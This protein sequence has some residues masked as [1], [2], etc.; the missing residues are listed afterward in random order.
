VFKPLFPTLKQFYSEYEMPLAQ[1]FNAIDRRGLSVDSAKLEAFKT[2]LNSELERACLWVE[3]CVKLKVVPK[4]PKGVK[5]PKGTLNLSSPTQ[6][7]KVFNEVLGIHFKKDRDTGKETS[8]EEALNEAY[9]RTGNAALKQVIIIRELNKIKGTYAEATLVD[10]VLY[11]SYNPAGTVSGRRSSRETPFTASDGRTIGTNVQNLPKHSELGLAF[12]ECIVARPGCVF[13]SCDQIS[14]EDWVVQAIIADNGGGSKGLDELKSGVN[15]HR[16]L[17]C[18]IFKKTPQ[19]CGKET[20][21]YFLGKKTR[22]AGNYGMTAPRMAEVLIKEVPD[23]VEGM[24]KTGKLISYCDFMLDAFHT[25]EPEI[26]NTF[27]YYVE[28]CLRDSR[29]L[30]TPVGRERYFFG[31]R[32]GADNSKLFKEAFSYIPQSTIG[33]NTGLSILY[34]E[35]TKPGLVVLD[36]H[37]AVTLEI[38]DTIKD[39]ENGVQLLR[40]AF[41]REFTFPNGIKISI[42]IEFELGYDMKNQQKFDGSC[43][44]K[45]RIGLQ[46][47]ANSSRPLEKV[48]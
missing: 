44:E 23:A 21:F 5:T 40:D 22:H 13:L 28:R 30:Q 43:P 27:Q 38:P 31:L 35:R 46:N 12:R 10:S 39:I 18:E 11:T 29:M 33:D 25:A 32:P 7:I 37:D 1:V 24:A 19:E 16:R 48:L 17:A 15:R 42:P 6:L 45:L 47:T 3:D 14:A 9:A 2:R 36:G 4:M 34:C 41:K 8:N 20:M 26:R